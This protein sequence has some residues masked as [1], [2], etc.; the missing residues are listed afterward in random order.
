MPLPR[1]LQPEEVSEETTVVGDIEAFLSF[2][3]RG[4][5]EERWRECLERTKAMLCECDENGVVY[6]GE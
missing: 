2:W 1:E 5:F 4:G 3:E 6:L